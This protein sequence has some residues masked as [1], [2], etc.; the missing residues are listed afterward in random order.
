MEL[1][2]SQFTETPFYGRRRMAV[3][4]SKKVGFAVNAKRVKRLMTAMG[5]QAIYP[6][7]NTSKAHPA[8][9]KYP[10]LLRDSTITLVM[11]AA[12]ACSACAARFSLSSVMK[13]CA[14][15]PAR[16]RAVH[17]RRSSRSTSSTNFCAA[18]GLRA[19]GESAEAVPAADVGGGR[20]GFCEPPQA[21]AAR[22]PDARRSNPESGRDM[23]PLY[24]GHKAKSTLRC[25]AT[26]LAPSYA[27]A[28]ETMRP[29]LGRTGPSAK[30][31]CG[32]STTRARWASVRVL[33]VPLK[34]VSR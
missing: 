30:R 31:T 1:I 22:Q 11:Y 15:Q 12:V 2:D 20:F 28:G 19:S 33:A 10:Y 25:A 24:S 18:A 26:R 27:E 9:E 14:T 32:S 16:S 8:H 21:A 5:L 7:P 4:L 23:A 29:R 34:S 6:K 13:F 17:K 3:W